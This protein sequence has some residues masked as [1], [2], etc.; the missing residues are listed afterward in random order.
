MKSC[1]AI[2]DVYVN[3][4]VSWFNESSFNQINGVHLN[5]TY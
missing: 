5:S 3:D 2:K 1:Q 4:M